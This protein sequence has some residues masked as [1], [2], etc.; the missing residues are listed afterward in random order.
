LKLAAGLGTALGFLVGLLGRELARHRIAVARGDATPRLMG[1]TKVS[2]AAHADPLGSYILPAVFVAMS[3][4]SGFTYPPFGW[5]KPPSLNIR[6]LRGG[7]RD[8]VIVFLAGPVVTGILAAAGGAATTSTTGY[9]QAL[10]FTF[11]F[12]NIGLTVFELLPIP[13][14][15]GGRLLALALSPQAAMKF[16]GYEE[17][18]MLFVIVLYLLLLP[19]TSGIFQAG[20]RALTSLCSLPGF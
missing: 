5:A 17:Y 14:R 16:R 1:R 20:C 11:T 18:H 15:D 8:A 19:L 12:V 10:L 9:L 2:L 7:R 3:M 13:G 4:F 6:A